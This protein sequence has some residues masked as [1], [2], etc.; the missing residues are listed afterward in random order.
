MPS[1]STPPPPFH[2]H[3]APSLLL[4]VLLAGACGS[5]AQ[6]DETTGGTD[7]ATVGDVSCEDLMFAD[8]QGG[9]TGYEQCS[10][11]GLY[12]KESVA[13][14]LREP[15]PPW[16][17]ACTGPT[18]AADDCESDDDCQAFPGGGTCYFADVDGLSCYC[19]YDCQTDADCGPGALCKCATDDDDW[20]LNQCI[21]AY[22]CNTDDDCPKG[23]R[24]LLRPPV[25]GS[26]SGPVGFVAACTGPDDACV[27]ASDCPTDPSGQETDCRY[28]PQQTRFVC[29]VPAVPE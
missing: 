3:G 17:V 7:S 21:P 26:G 4:F 9:P 27:S 13:C 24:C 18:N 10:D 19:H 23:E 8:P 12:R 5:K 28:D 11:G 16:Q 14:H 1:S 2:R 20:V 25:D 6:G 22:T 29:V 15:T